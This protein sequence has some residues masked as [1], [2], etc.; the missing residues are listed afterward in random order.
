[1]IR[2]RA[3]TLLTEFALY[4][5]IVKPTSKIVGRV[6]IDEVFSENSVHRLERGWVPGNGYTVL[7]GGTSDIGWWS[8][9][10]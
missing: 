2:D 10:Y 3:K 9:G 4:I 8:L 1:M 7:L 5:L 6:I